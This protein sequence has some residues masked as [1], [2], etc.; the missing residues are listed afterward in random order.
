M[1]IN[2]IEDMSEWSLVT[3]LS[4]LNGPK[5][6]PAAV[7]AGLGFARRPPGTLYDSAGR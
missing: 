6:N 3:S 5:T 1:W 7:V 4:A 2:P